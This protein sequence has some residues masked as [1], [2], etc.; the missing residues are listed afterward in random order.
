MY[1]FLAS[2]KSCILWG[3]LEANAV[4]HRIFLLVEGGQLLGEPGAIST[5]GSELFKWGVLI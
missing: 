1:R 3:L 4:R 2:L 5:F